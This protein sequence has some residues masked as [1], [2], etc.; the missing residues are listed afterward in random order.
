[1]ELIVLKSLAYEATLLNEFLKE[2]LINPE[3]KLPDIDKPNPFI[4][5]QEED[6]TI[7]KLAYRYRK[8]HLVF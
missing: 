8:F 4:T 1:M 5:D 6:Q 2:Q 7:E 3:E